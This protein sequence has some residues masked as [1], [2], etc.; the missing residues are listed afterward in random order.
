MLEGELLQAVH[1]RAAAEEESRSDPVRKGRL[2]RRGKIPIPN[3]KSRPPVEPP[4]FLVH[5]PMQLGSLLRYLPMIFG[6]SFKNYG[7]VFI[8]LDTAQ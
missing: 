6:Q 5:F 7:P 1:A 8:K 2:P 3:F 4:V